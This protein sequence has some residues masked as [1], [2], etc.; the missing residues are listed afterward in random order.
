LS[1]LK[2]ILEPS[3]FKG[4]E[5]EKLIEK[6]TLYDWEKLQ[7]VIQ[8]SDGEILA[9]LPEYLIAYMNGIFYL[10]FILM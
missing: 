9:A 8:A 2:I 5:Y 4:L 6:S 10:Y 1:K 3:S 7:N